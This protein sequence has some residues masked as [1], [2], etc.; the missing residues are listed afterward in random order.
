MKINTLI[1]FMTVLTMS[2]LLA[3]CHNTIEG[4]W[5]G[6]DGEIMI[7]SK[8]GTYQHLTNKKQ[9]SNTSSIP[10]NAA[11][12]PSLP[13]HWTWTV[14]SQGRYEV[15][16]KKDPAWIDLNTGTYRYTG[17]FLLLNNDVIYIK[18]GKTSRPTSVGP[19]NIYHQSPGQRLSRLAADEL[20]FH[21]ITIASR[22][23]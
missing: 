21:G 23:H 17:V 19:K 8:D 10:P 2:F 11:I 3:S 13:D 5:I 1:P 12:P 14:I 6:C 22:T 4:D 9:T 15:D 18:F 7:F 16:Y 20:V